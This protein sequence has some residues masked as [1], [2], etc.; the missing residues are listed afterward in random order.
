MG[1]AIVVAPSPKVW[2]LSCFRAQR[3]HWY[4]RGIINTRVPLCRIPRL[5]PCNGSKI[6]SV[7]R[8]CHDL[9]WSPRRVADVTIVC[10]FPPRSH[11]R[12]W[13]QPSAPSAF[14]VLKLLAWVRQPMQPNL[15]LPGLKG[16]FAAARRGRMLER[17]LAGRSWMCWDLGRRACRQSRLHPKNH[18]FASTQGETACRGQAQGT[19]LAAA[20]V[21]VLVSGAA[22]GSA[23][24][25]CWKPAGSA[26][27]D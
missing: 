13:N 22:L 12:A 15:A 26:L 5:V 18:R 4:R 3:R 16:R 27:S 11:C 21:R 14:I 17:L 23:R 2:L 1:L 7:K 8:S 19:S 6:P 9:T 10:R 24:S 20:K 25:A